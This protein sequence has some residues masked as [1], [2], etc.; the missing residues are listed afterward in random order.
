MVTPPPEGPPRVRPD[1]LGIGRLFD[2]ILDA[3]VVSDAQGRVVLW[4]RGAEAIFGYASEEAVGMPVSVLVPSHL[5]AR[6]TQGMAR[7]AATGRGPLLDARVAVEL[8]ALRKDGQEIHVELTLATLEEPDGRYAL[9]LIRDVTDRVR[10]RG[11]LERRSL[12]LQ[13]SNEALAQANDSLTAFTYV[14]SHDLKE[15]VRAI[16]T[17]LRVLKE[18]HGDRLPDDARDLLTRALLATDRLGALL[19]G[20]LELSRVDRA[21]LQSQRVTL[22]EV[23]QSE[24]CRGSYE[25]LLGERGGVLDTDDA[26]PAVQAPPSMLCQVLGNLVLN[27]LKHNPSPAP[28]VRV[29][30]AETADG[31]V[32]VRV[33]DDGPGFPPDFA[34]KFNQPADGVHA[35][36]LRGGFG[37]LIAR[38]A[39]E[40]MGGR[41]WV[42]KSETLGGASV[43]FTVPRAP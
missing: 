8:P 31:Y 16:D 22:H 35:G 37:L 9:A 6:H 23:L 13:R 42:D 28:R 27:A 2:A 29:T 38:R 15:P 1:D 7:F 43:R 34:Q 21:G 19:R 25:V 5:R 14:V 24:A 40:R 36:T 3:V 26:S 10:L 41:L 18:D 11:E 32:E 4:N 12:L 17:Y 39:A 30:G 33:E 20:L